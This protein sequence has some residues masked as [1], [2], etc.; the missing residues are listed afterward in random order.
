MGADSHP[1][2]GYVLSHS[3]FP[4]HVTHRGWPGTDQG[5]QRLVV[6]SSLETR[7]CALKELGP[8]PQQFTSK[9][10]IAKPGHQVCSA[11]HK[12]N[13]ANDAAQSRTL[14]SLRVF[15]MEIIIVTSRG[16]C[17]ELGTYRV[18]HLKGLIKDR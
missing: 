10:T 18:G 12:E 13:L 5:H 17:G 15:T 7:G 14:R 4:Q 8:K 11:G 6:V 3:Q 2:P 16:A 1:P 9:R